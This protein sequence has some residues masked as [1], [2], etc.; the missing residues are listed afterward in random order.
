IAELKDPALFAQEYPASAAEA[1]EM[2]GHDSFIPPA[3]VAAA[4]KA[5]CAPSGP[6]VIGFDPAWKGDDR[7]AMAWRQG[8]GVTRV[9]CRAKLDTRQGGGWVKKVIDT[10]RPRR[11]FI[12]IG[13]VGAGVHD[14]L[15]EMGFG[16]IV[17]GIN[18]GSAPFEPP[19]LDAHGRPSG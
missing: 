5:T 17:R 14:R 19:P 10:D 8:R 9:E 6:L 4:R 7:H 1:F 16:E 18:F 13:G 2:S 15:V 11:V 12:D 3:L